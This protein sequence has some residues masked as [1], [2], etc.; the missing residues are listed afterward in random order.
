MSR[1]GKLPVELPQGVTVTCGEG[2]IVTVKG[3]KGELKQW[4]NPVISIETEDGKLV[5]KRQN[6]EK[7]QKSLHGLYRALM[8]NMV[9]GVSEG[10]VRKLEINGVGYRASVQGN[11]L[12]LELGY[13]HPVKYDLPEGISA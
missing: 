8:A 2:N 10:F 13:S 9:K 3:P 12:N 6:D 7:S 11:A 4:V 1:I 5:L